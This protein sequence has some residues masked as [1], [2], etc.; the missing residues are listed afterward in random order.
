M[1]EMITIPTLLTILRLISGPIF[2][3]CG[4]VPPS[5]G[6]FLL[7]VGAALTDLIDG[8]LARYFGTASALGGALDTTADKIFVLSLLIKLSAAGVL[9]RWL[10]WLTA[11]QYLGIALEGSAYVLKFS[12]V[13]YPDF[14]AKISA[15]FATL[16]VLVGLV[17]ETQQFA[18]AL[19]FSMVIANFAHIVTAFLRVMQDT[20]T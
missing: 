3:F 4:T 5:R 14:A 8:R 6:Q 12:E 9:P 18:V 7:L 20:A 16:T 11:L 2:L 10:L 15:A 1:Y 13:P 19:G 17:P